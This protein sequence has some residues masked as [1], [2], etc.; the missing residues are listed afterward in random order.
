MPKLD[1]NPLKISIA[2]KQFAVLGLFDAILPSLL[3]SEKSEV[4]KNRGFRSTTK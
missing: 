4:P 2:V 1:E 3:T